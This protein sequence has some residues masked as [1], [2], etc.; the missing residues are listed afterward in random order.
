MIMTPDVNTG[1]PIDLSAVLMADVEISSKCTNV[2][3]PAIVFTSQVL[4][5]YKK[6]VLWVLCVSDR[7]QMH[8]ICFK[9][10]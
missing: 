8:N 6:P 5:E 9:L 7:I 10:M 4:Y 1:H 2:L 3:M